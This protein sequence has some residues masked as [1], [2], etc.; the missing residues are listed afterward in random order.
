MEAKKARENEFAKGNHGSRARFAST[1]NHGDF[2]E[3]GG[4]GRE[5]VGRWGRGRKQTCCLIPRLPTI[6]RG[7][8]RRTSVGFYPVSGHRRARPTSGIDASGNFP[9]KH[10]HRRQRGISSCFFPLKRI[11][12]RY[13]NDIGWITRGGSVAPSWDSPR[14]SP[15]RTS[16]DA[17]SLASPVFPGRT[18]V[19]AGPETLRTH[20]H[21][22][23]PRHPSQLP[24]SQ[25]L[26]RAL[27]HVPRLPAGL[28]IILMQ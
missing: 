10:V 5:W 26:R 21:G 4:G 22:S 9:N 25:R 28:I 15:A 1:T 6:P 24:N 3:V 2:P 12:N 8:F 23:V 18:G 13:G 17:P 16:P 11:Q 20:L 7:A 27:N 19:P 14:D